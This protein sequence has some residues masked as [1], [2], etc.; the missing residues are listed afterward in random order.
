[1]AS[2]MLSQQICCRPA[3]HSVPALHRARVFRSCRPARH[4]VKMAERPIQDDNPAEKAAARVEDNLEGF[5]QQ[6]KENSG[7]FQDT[8]SQQPGNKDARKGSP[9]D[10]S[11]AVGGRVSKYGPSA[12]KRLVNMPSGAKTRDQLAGITQR[13]PSLQRSCHPVASCPR[14]PTDVVPWLPCSLHSL[15]S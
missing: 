10:E 1:M 13:I 14:S 15:R 8:I 5:V 9:V 3:T 11:G 12:A 7:L 2:M 4:V 6:T